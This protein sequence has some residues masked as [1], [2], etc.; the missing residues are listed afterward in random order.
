MRRLDCRDTGRIKVSFLAPFPVHA[1]RLKSDPTLRDGNQA[2]R[3]EQT[4]HKVRVRFLVRQT[5]MWKISTVSRTRTA[6]PGER[7]GENR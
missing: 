2:T 4:N 1:Q 5:G 3:S 6:H 7:S